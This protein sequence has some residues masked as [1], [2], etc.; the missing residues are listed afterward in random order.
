MNNSKPFFSK[1]L[2]NLIHSPT[3][4]EIIFSYLGFQKELNLIKI[5]K[6]FQN[7]L[8]LSLIDYKKYFI[9][10]YTNGFSKNININFII[11]KL[12]QFDISNDERL[13]IFSSFIF[14][15]KKKYL[16]P[17][18][19]IDISQKDH[20]YLLN[21]NLDNILLNISLPYSLSKK[22]EI[23]D[24]DMFL[25]NKNIHE[26]CV[27]YFPDFE[28]DFIKF[29]IFSNCN[30][31]Y[32]LDIKLSLFKELNNNKCFLNLK[33][34]ILQR[35]SNF[36]IND[37]LNQ[38]PLLEKLCI[39]TIS[40]ALY[41][42]IINIENLNNLKIIKLKWV[43]L[44]VNYNI[45]SNLKYLSIYNSNIYT[46]SDNI[47]YFNSLEKIKYYF[48]K[49]KKFELNNINKD[50]FKNIIR[51][52]K[53]YSC[54]KRD[55]DFLKLLMNYKL[56]EFNYLL[57]D[58][59]LNGINYEKE[60]L[61]TINKLNEIKKLTLIHSSTNISSE[62]ILYLSYIKNSINPELKFLKIDCDY[63]EN[64]ILFLK[65]FLNNNIS[66]ETIII[67]FNYFI[68][69][70]LDD[71]LCLKRISKKK[72]IKSI[73][74]E[75]YEDKKTN[76]KD[77][78]FSFP[79]SIFKSENFPIIRIPVCSFTELIKINFFNIPI[80]YNLMSYF[81]INK[82]C[83]LKELQIENTIF[84]SSNK[85]ILNLFF[86]NFHNFRLIQVLKIIDPVFDND[87]LNNFLNN[88][89]NLIY[90]NTLI[91]NNNNQN[92][93]SLKTTKNFPQLQQLK[94]LNIVEI[95]NFSKKNKI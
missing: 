66:L 16:N 52:K 85:E 78:F 15:T 75:L 83:K 68:D 92:S 6:K 45:I 32:K 38:L 35:D 8:E 89:Y 47:L 23:K 50:S 18:F 13:R 30:Y 33:S 28:L 64:S 20:S 48:E 42:D 79:Q 74:F 2:Y 14:D 36:N 94:K 62:I 46:N 4:Y 86:N 37:Q 87:L 29:I 57:F 55:F 40:D 71:Y 72:M 82:K 95:K 44:K 25:N 77:I 5:S 53:F 61:E 41:D 39:Y 51:I 84:F 76:I 21:P 49:N 73:N 43:K 26:I 10:D 81:T 17:I 91:L 31:V 27:T 54:C 59:N 1:S 60:M 9:F 90:L 11:S 88:V 63:D 12:N 70:D 93:N 24:F 80:D 34:L 7:K 69:D 67:F 56:K 3:I 58:C 22:L 19:E 65:E